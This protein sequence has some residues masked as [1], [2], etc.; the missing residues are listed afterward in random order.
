VNED[1]DV[2]RAQRHCNSSGILWHVA[3]LQ[4]APMA[5][6]ATPVQS[7]EQLFPLQR[8]VPLHEPL[9]RQ[10]IVFVAPSACTPIAHDCGPEQVAWHDVP[11]QPTWPW[12]EPV[13]E[14]TIVFIVPAPVTP[15]LHEPVPAH[16]TLQG[17][18]PH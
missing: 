4:Q 5:H 10:V 16:V 12:H 17:L 8:T 15:P 14:Q 7:V 1:D 2:P 13:P 6:A 9:P 18:P 3:A 11:E